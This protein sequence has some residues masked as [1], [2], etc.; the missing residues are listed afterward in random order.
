MHRGWAP[1]SQ[2]TVPKASI[3]E[4]MCK[5]NSE[6]L[7]SH[8]AFSIKLLGVVVFGRIHLILPEILVDFGGVKVVFSTTKPHQ[9]P[10]KF[11]KKSGGCLCRLHLSFLFVLVFNKY[12]KLYY[13]V[14][15]CFLN[16]T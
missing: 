13:L 10:R 16:N 4:G 5:Y 12:D 15:F 11:Q 9:T 7:S 8:R 6:S 1:G 14:K 3:W 2:V